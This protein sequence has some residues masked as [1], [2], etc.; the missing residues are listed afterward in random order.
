MGSSSS[1]KSVMALVLVLLLVCV[2][3]NAQ[4]CGCASGVC[5]SQYGY[6]GT[7][8]AYC[9]KGCKSGPCYS[10]GGGSPS[11]GGGSVGGIISQS[12]FNGLAGGAGSSCEGKGF[13]TYNAFIAAANA[14]SGFGTTGSNNV[15]KRE[16]AAFFANVMH[17]TGGL[18]Y[19]NE[20]NPP[21]KYCQSSSTWPCTSGKSYHGRGPLQLSWNYNYGAA[22]KSI[23]FDGLNNPEK[24]G[25]DFTISFKTAVWFWMK[26]S[27]CHSAITSG[28]GFGGTIKAI[29]SME[30]NGGNSGEVSSRVNYYKKICSQLGVDPGANVSC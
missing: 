5:C 25:Q 23:G 22:G 24:V 9:G 30:C 3:V 13:Y 7:T 19:I 4:N 8:S 28:Q 11:G 6:C 14:F 12:F 18:C 26:N 10:S 20:K 29:N 27:N 1:D 16:L 17:E 21:M 15:K 2:S